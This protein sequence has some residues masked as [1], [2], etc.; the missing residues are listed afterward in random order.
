M[1]F[2]GVCALAQDTI[3]LKIAYS[4]SFLKVPEGKTWSI[5]RVFISDGGQY[6]IQ[7][8]TNHFR[9]SYNANETITM[10]YYISEMELLSNSDLMQFQ[11]YISET[12]SK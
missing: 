10:P 12:N 7:V 8:G 9:T 2:T 11:L 1:F 6:A 3:F 5:N 4:G